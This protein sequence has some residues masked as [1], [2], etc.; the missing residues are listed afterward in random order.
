MKV[1]FY[2]YYP[3]N[4]DI[5]TDKDVEVYVDQFNM[6]PIPPGTIRI[7]II[8]EPKKSELFTLV[9]WHRDLYTHVLTFHEE[10]LATNP[11]ARLF[12]AM[13]IWVRRYISKNKKFCVSTVVGGKNDPA[14]AGYAMRHDLWRRKES[15]TIPKDFFLSG[16]APFPHVFVPWGEANYRNNLVLGV[17][18]EPM[19]DSMFHIAIENASIRNYFS[20]K[21]L[22]CFQSRT[23]PVYYGCTNI[24]EFFNIDGIIAA[25]SVSEIITACNNLTPEKYNAMLPAIEDNFNRSEKW[26]V[27]DTDEWCSHHDRQIKNKIIEILNERDNM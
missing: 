1:K 24:G 25:N 26:C 11:K 7:I 3:I 17:S 20:E 4:A 5:D 23:V 12:L 22:D 21:I 13:N 6:N 19:F 16:N 10:I 8:D 27:G 15:I 2:S 18:K 14:M 9:Q